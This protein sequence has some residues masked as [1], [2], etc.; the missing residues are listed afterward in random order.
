MPAITQL[1]RFKGGKQDEMIAAAK[2]AKAIIEKH[3]AELFRISRFH[4]GNFAGEWLVVSRY[5]NWAAYGKA[6]DGLAQDKE[7]QKLLAHVMS[8]AEMTARNV[9]V[10]IDL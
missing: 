3:G 1:T 6:Q 4:T 8:I 10:G 9:T 5:A 7:F 2:K